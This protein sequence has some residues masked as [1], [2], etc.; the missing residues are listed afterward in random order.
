M[1]EEI[2]KSALDY[3]KYM[4]APVK[5]KENTGWWPHYDKDYPDDPQELHGNYECWEWWI[6]LNI[7]GQ[8]RELIYRRLALGEVSSNTDAQYKKI[9]SHL[10][11]SYSKEIKRLK[12]LFLP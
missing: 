3:E 12:I 1:V 8:Q 7:T 6:K 11:E 5:Q 2:I 9:L 4:V 10:W